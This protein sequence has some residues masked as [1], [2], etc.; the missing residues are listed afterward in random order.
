[1]TSAPAIGFEYRP[2]QLLR[3]ALI[4]L[5][6]LALLALLLRAVPAWLKLLLALLVSAATWRVLRRL[7]A[8]PVAAA[9]WSADAA[10]PLHLHAEA[11]VQY[12]PVPF[13]VLGASGLLG[14]QTAGRGARGV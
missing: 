11:A 8:D 4:L 5:A 12:T 10:W 13:S 1:M 14:L 6:V 7:A 2:S 9:G 3:R